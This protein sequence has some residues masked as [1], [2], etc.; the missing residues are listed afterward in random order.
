MTGANSMV[1]VVDDDPSIR[2]AL[3]RLIRSLDIDCETFGL[4]QEVL[5][6]L[7][8]SAPGCI[9]LDV[10]MP[11]LSGLELQQELARRGV[12]IP[13]VFISGQ[14][15]IPTSVSAMKAGATDYLTKPI[16]ERDLIAA[17]EHALAKDKSIRAGQSELDGIRERLDGLTPREYEVFQKVVVGRL[18]K[19]IAADLGTGEK[20]I[21]VH[22]ARVMSKMRVSSVAELA[23]LAE[24]AGVPKP[25]DDHR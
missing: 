19:Q 11:G 5:D 12:R 15:D 7:S 22:R 4:A 20:T 8:H 24:R 2:R 1:Y 17:I 23:R 18:N 10:M 13:V 25:T 3:S 21:K 14:G 6:R 16:D 9:L